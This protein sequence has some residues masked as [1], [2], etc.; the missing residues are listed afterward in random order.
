MSYTPGMLLVSDVLKDIFSPDNY[1][2]LGGHDCIKVILSSGRVVVV[3]GRYLVE[4]KP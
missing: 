1:Q 2:Y 3:K 4:Y